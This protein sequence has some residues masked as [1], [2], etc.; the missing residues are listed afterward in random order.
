[1]VLRTAQ[2]MQY[3]HDSY[4]SCNV[5]V[6][7]TF[8]VGRYFYVSICKLFL[9]YHL[10][11][12]VEQK[13]YYCVFC[14]RVFQRARP[15]SDQ[16]ENELVM[17]SL[18]SLYEER[19]R[20]HQHT[21]PG[22]SKQVTFAHLTFAHIYTSVP[23]PILCLYSNYVLHF[24]QCQQ[25]YDRVVHQNIIHIF[26]SF[27][28]HSHKCHTIPPSLTHSLSCFLSLSPFLSPCVCRCVRRHLQPQWRRSSRVAV[29]RDLSSSRAEPSALSL[30]PWRGSG[31]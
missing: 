11:A 18:R 30:S 23:A 4:V 2:C 10:F 21:L 8:R 15:K 9:S 24:I 7:K 26:Y 20:S 28:L 29:G 27:H 1:M 6:A 12:S 17:A 31:R 3:S 16:E 5:A 14:A 13:I 25:F 19:Q 22:D